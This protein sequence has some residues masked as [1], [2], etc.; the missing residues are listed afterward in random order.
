M[1][2][3]VSAPTNLARVR[4]E[5]RLWLAQ[6][7]TAMVLAVCVLV[8]LVT[9]ILA[10]RGGLSASE[11]LARTRGSAAWLTFY[12]SFVLMVAVHAPIGLRT[13][14]AETFGWRGRSLDVA[15]GLFATLLLAMG[16]RT[17]L[18]LYR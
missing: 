10:I 4:W 16:W 3:P 13:I 14:M 12:G 17:V 9:I 15:T 5:A 1:S 6:R 2:A 7:L 8:H 18:G 11:I